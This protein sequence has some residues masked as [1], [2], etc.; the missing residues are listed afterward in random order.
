MQSLDSKS[1]AAICKECNKILAS[2]KIHRKEYDYIKEGSVNNF[3]KIQNAIESKKEG[4]R[5]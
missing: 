4:N 2:N 1:A 5:S 3:K